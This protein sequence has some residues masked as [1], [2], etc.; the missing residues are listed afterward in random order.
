VAYVSYVLSED[1]AYLDTFKE[2]LEAADADYEATLTEDEK[3]LTDSIY[4]YYKAIYDALPE[5]EPQPEPT[6]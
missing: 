4:N 2:K 1:E 5:P 3:A 6:E